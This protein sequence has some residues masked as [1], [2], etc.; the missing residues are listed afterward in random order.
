[1]KLDAIFTAKDNKLIKIEDNSQVDIST[2]KKIEIKWSVVEIEEEKYNEEYLANLR[3]E[4][5]ILE[6]TNQFAILVPVVDKPLNSAEEIELFD[7][8]INHTARRVKDCISVVG[9]EIPLEFASLGENAVN[10]F[11]EL[12]S[13]KHAQYV[14]FTKENSISN[15]AIIK[16]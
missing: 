16:Y 4:L 14:Y 8:A 9:I 7:N 13:K 12:L 5:K 3:D 11:I 1:M 15:S 6:N 2:I 10:E